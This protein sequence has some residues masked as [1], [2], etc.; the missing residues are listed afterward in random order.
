MPVLQQ[1]QVS[2]RVLDLGPLEKPQ[3]A[4]HAVG[5][6]GVE[7]GGLHH[8]A[9]R[10]AAVKQ[11]D[12]AAIGALA[13]QLPHLVDKPLRLGKVAGRLEHTHR[14]ARPGLGVQVLAQAV[15]IAADEGIGRIEDVAEAAVIAL[16]L[17]LMR[18][19]KLTHE[20]GHIAHP[21]AAK[22]IDA[23]VVVAD[24]NHRCGGRPALA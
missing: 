13:H 24:G 19:A 14:L 20:V 2:Q 3:A 22:G 11:R 9:L 16:K 17:D 8:P 12:L 23:L 7:Q 5:N 6:A 1:A 18:H 15:G 10:I 4:V 21:G